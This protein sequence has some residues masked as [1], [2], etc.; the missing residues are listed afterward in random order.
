MSKQ[1][2]IA[3]AGLAG[4]IAACHFKKAEVFEAGPRI[5]Q[6]RALLRFRGE[7]VSKVTGIP[8]RAVKV[9]KAVY[10]GNQMY[11]GTCPLDL[12]NK[13]SYKVT[14]GYTG[15][16]IMKLEPGVRYI[17]PDDFYERLIDE[18]GEHRIH[19]NTPIDKVI[20]D[21]KFGNALQGGK[22]IVS[23]IPMQIMMKLLDMESDQNIPFSFHRQNVTVHR[24]NVNIKCD[25]YQ[26]IYFPADDLKTYRASI[27]GN[28]FII[29]M[30]EGGKGYL[31]TEH[32]LAYIVK[33]F[34]IE[35]HQCD[36][37]SVETVDQ[38]YG[39]IV[40]MPTDMRQA[41]LYD[42]TAKHDV[43]SV[44][45]FA[46]WRNLLLDDVVGDLKKLEALIGATDYNRFK[47]FNQN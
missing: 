22:V 5:Q 18:V 35:P 13:Y 38:K 23:T 14:G 15:R 41:I 42:M 17:A 21:M 16:S 1:I 44:G 39:K 19:F 45:R 37:D 7:D 40:D 6:H 36:L 29:E 34:G 20:S 26:T 47:R 4:L 3:G 8:F 31:A 9:E 30:V 33:K 46:T 2:A 12:A 28:T 24:F 43:F 10:F 27:T 32:E 11:Q 25:L